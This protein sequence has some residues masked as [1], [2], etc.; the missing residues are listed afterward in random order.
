M[1]AGTSLFCRDGSQPGRPGICPPTLL[2]PPLQGIARADWVPSSGDVITCPLS[3]CRNAP[4]QAPVPVD[5]VSRGSPGEDRVRA[6]S[7]KTASTLVSRLFQKLTPSEIS[8]C[9]SD[10]ASQLRRVQGLYARI[11]NVFADAGQ[12]RHGA[13]PAASRKYHP[14][15]AVRMGP[16]Q[17]LAHQALLRGHAIHKIGP[18]AGTARVDPFLARIVRIPFEVRG[19]KHRG[20]LHYLLG[21]RQTPPHLGLR[22]M[23]KN[24]LRQDEI[25]LLAETGQREVR[26]VTELG[27]LDT[28]QVLPVSFFMPSSINHCSGSTP[29][30]RP[31]VLA[32]EGDSE[33]RWWE[34]NFSDYEEDRKKR[35]GVDADQPHRL[36]YKPLVRD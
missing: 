28:D 11:V 26:V 16:V 27:L 17:M 25:E 10:R 32:F 8:E 22:G 13:C 24:R 20:G 1:P 3:V 12:I 6:G 2:D 21:F 15:L 9:P 18:E 19:G 7:E 31:G 33:V 23:R 34:G 5:G 36:R 30:Y 29:K 14:T 4:A 35:L